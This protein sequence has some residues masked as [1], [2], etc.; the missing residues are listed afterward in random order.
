MACAGASYDIQ[1]A[2]ICTQSGATVM[3]CL[4]SLCYQRLGAINPVMDNILQPGQRCLL[5]CTLETL[6]V[7]ARYIEE[8]HVPLGR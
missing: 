5:L 1:G 7:A 6:T 3:S 2:G 8:T 4:R